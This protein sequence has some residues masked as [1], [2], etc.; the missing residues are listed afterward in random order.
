MRAYDIHWITVI[1]PLRR[2]PE[3]VEWCQE[4]RVMIH[5]IRCTIKREQHRL[6]RQ[7]SPP[8]DMSRAASI[9]KMLQSDAL[10]ATL[11]SV[12]DENGELT[13]NGKE[14]EDVMVQHFE[15]VFSIP[16]PIPSHSI[17]SLRL[18]CYSI[19]LASSRS[20]TTVS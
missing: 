13:S 14:L 12:V 15:A 9:D 4:T 17:R 6:H 10:P 20:G 16:P 3:Y 1:T 18:P 7:R 2:E 8:V 5:D 19:S 11:Y